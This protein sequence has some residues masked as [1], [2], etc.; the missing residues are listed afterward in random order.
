[1]LITLFGKPGSGKTTL[2]DFLE[3]KH[4]F[5]HLALSRLLRDEKFLTEVSISRTEMAQ[6]FSAGATISAPSLFDWLDRAILRS[7]SD[8]VVDGYPREPAAL[9]RFNALA[10]QLVGEREVVALKILCSR[11]EAM[12]RIAA[13]AREDDTPALIEQRIENY[14]TVQCAVFDQLDS[15]IRR[16]LVD[17]DNPSAI[18]AAALGGKMAQ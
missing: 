13:R 12:K 11:G 2:G 9:I 10:R 3:L 17:S 5:I 16:L 14:I 7:H 18:A 15:S 1:M 6:A 4:G 8:V